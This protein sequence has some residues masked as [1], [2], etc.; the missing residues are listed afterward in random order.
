MDASSPVGDVAAYLDIKP[1]FSLADA[2]KKR[3]ELAAGES[4]VTREGIWI[5]PNWLRVTGEKDAASGLIARRHELE[6]LDARIGEVEGIIAE[7]GERLAA[8]R[9]RWSTRWR[10]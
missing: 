9:E 8:G 7:L 1:Q 4:I 3:N 10:F 2:L 6:E 5:G